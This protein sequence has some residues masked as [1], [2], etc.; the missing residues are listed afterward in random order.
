MGSAYSNVEQV[1]FAPVVQLAIT[2]GTDAGRTGYVGR[3]NPLYAPIGELTPADGTVAG[4]VLNG[5]FFFD[6]SGDE[7]FIIVLTGA[8]SDAVWS[9]SFTDDNLT[10]WTFATDTPG[11]IY[12]DQSGYGFWSFSLPGPDFPLFTDGVVY[13]LTVTDP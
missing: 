13:P 2:S 3:D 4:F 10:V 7:E 5:L 11:V 1:S 6:S 12:V 9:V 8:P